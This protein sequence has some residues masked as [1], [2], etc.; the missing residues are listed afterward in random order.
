M[1]S[2]QGAPASGLATRRTMQ[3]F[4]LDDEV[5]ALE[6]DLPASAGLER[7]D[8]LLRLS[9]QLRQRDGGRSELLADEA[10]ALLL[11]TSELG[12]PEREHAIASLQLVRAELRWLDA[13][14]VQAER[15][16][17]AKDWARVGSRL[18]RPQ[19]PWQHQAA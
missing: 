3:L 13:D 4:A 14:L 11:A 18:Y 10:E 5:A 2:M 15:L 7:L 17:N 9:W 6:A 16:A 19:C 12:Q 1:T 8:V